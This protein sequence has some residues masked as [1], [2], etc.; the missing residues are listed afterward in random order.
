M[1]RRCGTD[2]ARQ[3]HNPALGQLDEIE[4]ENGEIASRIDRKRL[5]SLDEYGRWVFSLLPKG[6]AR[7]EAP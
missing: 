4:S 3:A 6:E 1:D 5:A 2:V 7:G